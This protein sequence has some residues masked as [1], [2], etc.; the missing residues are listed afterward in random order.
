M[1]GADGMSAA[2]HDTTGAAGPGRDR[3]LAVC[4]VGAGRIGA[5]HAGNML[6]NPDV[7]VLSVVDTNRTA[8]ERVAARHPHAVAHASLEEACAAAA[9]DAVMICSPTDTH[10]ALI[11]AA[12]RAGLAIF[13]EK[14]VDLDHGRVLRAVAALDTNPVP[15]MI[16]FHRRRDPTHAAARAAV[17]SGQVG[18]I[19]QMR[20]LARDPAPPP[21]DYLKR[22]GGIFRDMMIHDLDQARFLLGEEFVGVHAVGGRLLDPDLFEAADDFDTATA[23]FWTAGGTV[24]TILNARRSAVGFE[25]RVE[26]FGAEGTVRIDNPG[27]TSLTIDGAAGRCA[28]VLDH[29]FPERYASAYRAELAAFVEAVAGGETPTPGLEDA[30]RALVL[31]DAAERSARGN[32]SVAIDF[33]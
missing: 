20:L 18:R 7:R 19:V 23:M 21:L 10:L 9:L 28:D 4:L 33:G 1:T 11:E 14:P 30:R 5:L 3:P 16:G 15:F 26:L 27:R 24:C 29:H 13:C 6:A 22:S 2:S 8:A 32:A 31:A 17:R 12:A 25:Q